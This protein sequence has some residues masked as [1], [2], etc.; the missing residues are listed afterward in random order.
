MRERG[1]SQLAI[2]GRYPVE[3][4]HHHGHSNFDRLLHEVQ[5]PARHEGS[6]ADHDEERPTRYSRNLSGVRHEDLQDRCCQVG[7]VATADSCANSTAKSRSSSARPV[8]RPLA[9]PE[10]GS[11]CRCGPTVRRTARPSRAAAAYLPRRL[12]T[13]LAHAAARVAAA[14][15]SAGFID[16]SI[17]VA[18]PR[19]PREKSPGS[20]WPSV[21]D[22]GVVYAAI[23]SS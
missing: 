11:K 16:S 6:R 12:P 13:P 17:S 21:N 19:A 8:V 1:D 22:N 7:R 9:T 20:A 5:G 4:I 2:V 14:T 18:G 23:P 10:V 3:E 15:T